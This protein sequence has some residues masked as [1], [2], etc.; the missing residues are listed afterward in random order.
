MTRGS[1]RFVFH[2]PSRRTRDAPWQCAW[3]GFHAESGARTAVHHVH[4]LRNSSEGPGAFEKYRP[5]V[6][7]IGMPAIGG[8][9]VGTRFGHPPVLRIDADQRQRIVE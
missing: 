8:H 7:V 4:R 3:P 2:C 1:R 6:Q 9:C 5:P